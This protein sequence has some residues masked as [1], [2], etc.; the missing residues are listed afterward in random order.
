MGDAVQDLLRRFSALVLPLACANGKE[1]AGH[2]QIVSAL[3]P[4]IFFTRPYL[5]CERGFNEHTN[6]LLRQFVPE[7]ENPRTLDPLRLQEATDRLNHRP[8]K[9]PGY[10]AP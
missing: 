4:D 2:R 6:G 5:F 3:D 8:R 9:V 1:C 7:A 10:R